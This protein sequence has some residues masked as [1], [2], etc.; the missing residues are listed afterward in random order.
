MKRTLLLLALAGCTAARPASDPAPAAAPDPA[1]EAAKPADTPAPG[2]IAWHPSLEAAKE[3]SRKDG[4]PIMVFFEF[5][6]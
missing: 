4:K 6:A 2:A 5:D 3:A 1:P